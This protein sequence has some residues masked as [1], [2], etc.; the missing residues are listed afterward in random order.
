MWLVNVRVIEKVFTPEEKGQMLKG[1]TE[2]L[3]GVE[4]EKVRE[5]T[6]VVLDAL[7]SGDYAASAAIG[8][9][10]SMPTSRP[11]GPTRRAAS[12][13][14]APVPRA[15]SSTGRRDRRRRVSPA[16]GR[17]GGGTRHGDSRRPRDRTAW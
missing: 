9:A 17:S 8:S 10:R 14:A 5:F 15:R 2:A 6:V 1:I 7:R 16:L 11:S 12:A 3:I 4:G 13:R